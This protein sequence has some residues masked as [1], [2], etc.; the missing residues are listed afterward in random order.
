VEDAAHQDALAT[1]VRVEIPSIATGISTGD[2]TSEPR[3][4]KDRDPL[5]KAIRSEAFTPPYAADQPT[6]SKNQLRRAHPGSKDSLHNCEP[7]PAVISSSFPAAE[8]AY[9]DCSTDRNPSGGSP[10]PAPPSGRAWLVRCG[11][12]IL[13][14]QRPH[15]A[16][17]NSFDSSSTVSTP[18]CPYAGVPSG[19]H[20]TQALAGIA[21]IS[22]RYR[23]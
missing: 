13:F 2:L 22:L 21:P 17:C 9:G 16:H 3:Q 5:A 6:R 10:G 4:C 14:N 23:C 1:P 12:L 8:L 20:R 11:L 15:L 7:Q 18:I 19:K